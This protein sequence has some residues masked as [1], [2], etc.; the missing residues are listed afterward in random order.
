M[1]IVES[2]PFKETEISRQ[3]IMDMRRSRLTI[4]Y[5][6]IA[7]RKFSR[8]YPWILG[9]VVA[10]YLVTFPVLKY[11]AFVTIPVVLAGW[12][13]YRGAGLIARVLAGAADFFLIH[14]L[15]MKDESNGFSPFII[16]IVGHILNF[17]LSFGVGFLREQFESF[18]R[19]DR[20]LR[21]RERHLTLVNITTRDLFEMKN[22]GD[23]Y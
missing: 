19:M 6:A 17:G 23:V 16:D 11:P 15:I 21:S 13:Y 5:E 8:Y 7:T 10:L 12:F 3:T 14:T 1:V 4:W 20:K 9:S 2:V 22:S 18:F